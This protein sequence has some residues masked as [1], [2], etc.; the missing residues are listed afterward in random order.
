[1]M[2][3]NTPATL[4]DVAELA[5]VSKAVASRAL[6]GKNRPIS[7]DKKARVCQAAELLGYVANPFAQS[8]ANQETGLVAIV[9]NH[10]SN[11]S[12]L[13]L[14]DSLIQGIQSIGK[15]A[16][17]VRLKSLQ[18]IDQLQ[19]NA[20]IQRVDAALVLSDLIE[21]QLAESLFYTHNVI[22]LN[23]KS[24]DRGYSVKVN[25][26]LG[27]KDAIA[28]AQRIG[29]KRAVLIAGRQSSVNEEQRVEHYLTH[30]AQANIKLES[31]V[32]CD[33]SYDEALAY[34]TAANI[35]MSDELGIFCTSDSMAM[36]AVDYCQANGVTKYSSHIFGFDNTEFSRRGCYQFSTIGF[37]KHDFVQSIITLV[38]QAQSND[39]SVANEHNEKRL[40]TKESHLII[41]TQFYLNTP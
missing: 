18:D 3:K 25:E 11:V 5:G 41:D 28:Y 14:F 29:I 2:K 24:Q 37:D 30:L 20:F 16:L 19:K 40:P 13:T 35:D 1:M 26:A 22:M 38:K 7:A 27:I 9:I 21:P 23:G 4:S 34:L 36:A 32:F 10:I 15:Q 6:S 17:F 31:S 33:Y 39:L 8:L 12:D